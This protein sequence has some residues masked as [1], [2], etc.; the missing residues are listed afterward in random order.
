MYEPPS[1][2][3]LC[4]KDLTSPVYLAIVHGWNMRICPECHEKE[5]EEKEESHDQD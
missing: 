3:T 1:R 4:H 2:C 5:E